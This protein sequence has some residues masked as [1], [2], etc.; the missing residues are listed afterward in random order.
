MKENALC[1]LGSSSK[2]NEAKDVFKSVKTLLCLKFLR[3]I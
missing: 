2:V 1:V 3:L